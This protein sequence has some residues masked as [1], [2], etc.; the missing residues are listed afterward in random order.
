MGWFLIHI[1]TIFLTLSAWILLGT[2]FL[3]TLFFRRGNKRRFLGAI[4]LGVLWGMTTYNIWYEGYLLF[5]RISLV[6]SLNSWFFTMLAPLFYLY[7][8]FR[9]TRCYPGRLQWIRH[10]FLPG[11][12]AGFY[13]G[14]FLLS[15]VQDKLIYNWHEFEPYRASWWVLFRICCYACLMVQLII[16]LPRLPQTKDL[17]LALYM[18]AFTIVVMVVPFYICTL[19]YNLAI[20]ALGLHLL[21]QSALIRIFSR[22]IRAYIIPN[23]TIFRSA[24]SVEEKDR[25]IVFTAEEAERVERLLQSPDFLHNPEL[26]IGMLARELT[27]NKTYLSRYFNRQLGVGFPEYVTSLRLNEAEQLLIGT[28]KMVIEIS[29]SVGFKNY[30]TFSEAFKARNKLTPAE[31]RNR[32]QFKE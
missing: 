9:R 14:M 15:P 31:W 30:S 1:L 7:F 17:K 12:L 8:R 24:E 10:L 25:V 29:E 3:L 5:E 32:S 26:K 4:I 16:Y 19:L 2:S 11:V 22:K 13:V 18:G 20:I 21:R 27:T 28:D 23:L 6:P